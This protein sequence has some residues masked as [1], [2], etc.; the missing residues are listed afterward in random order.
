MFQ[1]FGNNNRLLFLTAILLLFGNVIVLGQREPMPMDPTVQEKPVVVSQEEKENKSKRIREGTIFRNKRVSFR[2]VG[3]RTMLLA[4]EGSES[5]VCLENLNLE[6]IL[7]AID[8]RPGRGVWTVDGEF[9]E[10]RGENYV[11]IKRAVLSPPG[12]DLGTVKNNVEQAK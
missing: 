11:L 4:L 2:T 9:T 12:I 10:F 1:G 6:R 3:Q 7:K 8:E 5:H